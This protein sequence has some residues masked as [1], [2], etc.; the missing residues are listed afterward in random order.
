[1]A[2]HTV[3]QVNKVIFNVT[4]LPLLVLLLFLLFT[5]STRVT[6]FIF[7]ETSSGKTSIEKVVEFCIKQ[8]EDCLKV[9]TAINYGLTGYNL[10]TSYT[11]RSSSTLITQSLFH[12]LPTNYTGNYRNQVF[13]WQT[14]LDT[15]NICPIKS[16]FSN[17]FHHSMKEGKKIICNKQLYQANYTV[18]DFAVNVTSQNWGNDLKVGAFG[19]VI[20]VATA[21]V[22]PVLGAVNVVPV[23]FNIMDIALNNME[24]NRLVLLKGSVLVYGEKLNK[25]R[26]EWASDHH[27]LSVIGFRCGYVREYPHDPTFPEIDCDMSY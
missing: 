5:L 4:F 3:A 27:R 12:S 19:V 1:V 13:R 11:V 2:V 9:G 22:N 6:A 25:E 16:T 14:D 26:S 20:T 17:Y 23:V 10:Y 7:E 24:Y 18:L 8:P 15:K 21:F